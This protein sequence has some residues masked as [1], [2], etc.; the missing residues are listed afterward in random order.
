MYILGGL[1]ATGHSSTF[2]QYD[3]AAMV[4]EAPELDG[5]APGGKLLAISNSG[6]D[7]S[8]SPC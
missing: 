8:P 2:A 1:D 7:H 3:A 6:P 4:W 5:A